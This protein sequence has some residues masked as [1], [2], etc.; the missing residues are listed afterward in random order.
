M[1]RHRIGSAVS[2]PRRDP[3]A[4]AGRVAADSAMQQ[5]QQQASNTDPSAA[6]PEATSSRSPTS[7]SSQALSYARALALSSFA[8]GGGVILSSFPAG[9]ATIPLPAY[10]AP[11]P[12][13]P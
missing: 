8:S 5:Q 1:D 6:V 7:S 3:P 12:A 10:R 2:P 4:D 11:L 9:L 13:R